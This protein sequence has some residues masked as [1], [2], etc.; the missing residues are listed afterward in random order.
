MELIDIYLNDILSDQLKSAGMPYSYVKRVMEDIRN[1]MLSCLSFWNREQDRKAI[2]F[3]SL[4][5]ALFYEPKAREGI[6]EFVVTTIRNSM[7]EIAASENYRKLKLHAPLSNEQ[8][9]SI[10]MEAIKYFDKMD[11]EEMCKNINEEFENVY[12][13]AIEKYP[14][15][16]NTI[17]NLANLNDDEMEFP[18]E[19]GKGTKEKSDINLESIGKAVVCDGY[20]LEFDV[21]LADTIKSVISGEMRALYSDCFKMVSRNFEKVLH[22]LQILLENEKSFCTCNYYISVNHLEKRRRILK[23]AHDEKE[24]VLNMQK[25]NSPRMI[26]ECINELVGE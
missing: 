8:I 17:K 2:L 9:K 18:I 4:E 6:R 16:W 19:A 21:Q 14:L 24:V 10:T 11:F 1:R 26:R 25:K 3:F 15:A 20:T 5:E 22:I 23:A 12:F 7:L 13:S